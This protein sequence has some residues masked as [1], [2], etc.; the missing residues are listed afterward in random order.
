MDN[1]TGSTTAHFDSK[2]SFQPTLVDH[3]KLVLK[4]HIAFFTGRSILINQEYFTVN[5]QLVMITLMVHV[6]LPL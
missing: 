5:H 6:D 4:K 2:S 1:A 3:Y